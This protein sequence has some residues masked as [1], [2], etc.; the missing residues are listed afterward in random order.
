MNS[1]QGNPLTRRI[2][3]R[4]VGWEESRRLV[5][6]GA[7]RFPAKVNA[8]PEALG[9]YNGA[10]GGSD[11]TFP[12]IDGT[13]HFMKNGGEVGGRLGNLREVSVINEAVASH[14][15]L[16][17]GKS[18]LQ[19]DPGA[20]GTEQVQCRGAQ[21]GPDCGARAVALSDTVLWGITRLRVAPIGHS[22]VAESGTD[23]MAEAA[24]CVEH[25]V[26]RGLRSATMQKSEFC[27]GMD[28][29]VITRFGVV[30]AHGRRGAA[31]AN[32]IV[33]KNFVKCLADGC[34]GLATAK[35]LGGEDTVLLSVEHGTATQDL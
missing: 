17:V 18:R 4:E 10:T 13:L 14:A 24:N 1:L 23:M 11:S 5:V 15:E 28:D 31:L 7:V 33:G 16:F 30:G 22:G 20:L 19:I 27:H 25:Q 3:N 6:I 12:K 35:L 34:K 26:H 32:Q 2:Q 29:P 21:D 9:R 8:I